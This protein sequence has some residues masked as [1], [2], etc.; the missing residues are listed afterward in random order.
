MARRIRIV[1]Y[2]IH[3]CRGLDGRVQPARIVEVLRKID[4]D[5]IALQEV[6]S[7][8]GKPEWDQARFIATELGFNYCLGE[9]RRLHGGAY[10]N[11]LLSRFPMRDYE[12]HDITTKK[13]EQRGCLRSD[14]D[15]METTLHVFN[16]HLGTSFLERRQQARKLV[17]PAILQNSKLHGPR[18][19][20]GDFND[21]KHGL[22][23]QLL[24]AHFKSADIWTQLPRFRTYPGLL[25]LLHLDHMYFDSVLKIERS[26]LYKSRT[27]LIASDHLPVIADFG[28]VVQDGLTRQHRLELTSANRH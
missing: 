26:R 23:S 18:I 5:I 2:N 17:G 24:S 4:A 1:T 28:M 19:V 9:N 20:L 21:W 22:P 8:P 6:L 3:K 11:I 7:V 27:A 13:R 25:P 10:G 16:V 15:L 12:N 14:I